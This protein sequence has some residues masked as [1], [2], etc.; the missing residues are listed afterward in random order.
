MILKRIFFSLIFI[1]SI[2]LFSQTYV[3][4][5]TADT[6][7]RSKLKSN[8]ESIFAS[9]NQQLK[10][11]YQGKVKS[12]LLSNSENFQKEFYE[13]IEDGQFVSDERFQ[14]FLD[15]ILKELRSKNPEIPSNLRILL[16]KYP[17]VNAYAM[18][19]GTI[20]VN[21]GCFYFLE[22]EDQIASIVAH[23]IAHNVLNHVLK[24]QVKLI[25]N[26]RSDAFKGK[27]KSIQKK[28]YGKNDQAF[29]MMQNILYEEGN[30]KRTHEKEADSLGFKFYAETRYKDDEFINAFK[31]LQRYDTLKPAGLPVEAFQKYFD[32]PNQAF[33][34]KWLEMEDFSQYDYSKF[35][36]KIN[37][38]SI[39]SHP[40]ALQ[41]I[42]FLQKS[43]PKLNEIAAPVQAGNDFLE[44]QKVA[45]WE[46]APNLFFLKEYGLSS[47]ICLLRLNK[48]LDAD[49]Y[50]YWLGKNFEKI[51]EARKQYKLN[52]YLETVN[53]KEQSESY[54]QFLSFMW[55][56]N[57]DELKN[58][59]DYYTRNGNQ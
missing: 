53:P 3:P 27:V 19:D 40:E 32:L 48:G 9:Y 28:K 36:E 51:Y 21:M 55:N 6:G 42:E 41:R 34:Q 30:M 16:S 44:L 18:P 38:D 12:E 33:N 39:S 7:F 17:N 20:V 5:D 10:S 57:L 2:Q 1:F 46:E 54:M 31:L 15:E 23:E 26:Q 43:F 59:A 50:G 14:N 37:Q 24:S 13:E 58:I 22:N 25:E 45:E 49:Y 11:D 35:V 47:Y 4:I 29:Q 56:L 52:R 8:Y